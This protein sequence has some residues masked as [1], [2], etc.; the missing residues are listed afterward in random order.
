[1]AADPNDPTW[2]ERRLDEVLAEYL[3]ALDAGRA[4]D[5]AA[6]LARHPELAADLREFFAEQERLDRWT[7]PLRPVAFAAR[8]ER[9]AA[10][11]ASGDGGAG[12]QDDTRLGAVGAF[13]DYDLLRV[14][15]R[16]GMGVVYEARHRR[17]HRL[18]AL[19]MIPAGR[20]ASDTDWQRFR[21]EAEAV[22]HLDH[23]H[24]VP[25]YEVGEHDRRPY[26]SMRRMEGGALADH[27]PRYGGD[28][29]SAARLLIEVAR[30]AHYAHQRGILHRDLKPANVLLDGEGRPYVT[31]FGLAKRLEGAPADEASLT[32]SGALVGSPGYMA[33]EQTTGVRGAVTVASDVYGLGAM[34]YALLT[35][36]PPFRGEDLLSTLDQT[37]HREPE[38]PRKR[39][40]RVDRDLELICLKCLEKDPRR[41]YPGAEALAEELERYLNGRPLAQTRPVGNAERLWRLCRRNPV[42]ASLT[43]VVVV[44]L[45]TVTAVSVV[46][47]VRL[48]EANAQERAS[49]AEAVANRQLA[50]DSVNR[51]FK[52]VSENRGLRA[53]GL[54]RFREELLADAKELY[55]QL[56][57][58]KGDDPAVEAQRGLA[59]WRLAQIT[60]ELGDQREAFRLYQEARAIFERL[61]RDRPQEPDYQV[62][63]ADTL[64]GLGTLSQETGAF[65]AA[66]QIYDEAVP[67][68]E[69]LVADHPDNAGYQD[70]LA[71][72]L[73]Q[74]ARL[75]QLTGQPTRARA[76]LDRALPLFERLARQAPAAPDVQ[77]RLARTYL[78]LGTLHLNANPLEA[79]A[80]RANYDRALPLFARLVRDYPGVP[81]YED[82]LAETLH[83]RGTLERKTNRP[84]EALAS[85]DRAL[86]YRRGL[87]RG[88]EDVPGYRNELATLLH[89]RGLAFQILGRWEE[90][91]A[92]FDE[93]LPL[94]ERLAGDRG[95]KPFYKAELGVL[96]YDSACLYSLF[97]AAT[98][99]GAKPSPGAGRDRAELLAARAVG[100]LRQAREVGFFNNPSM[101]EL[102][103]RGDADLEP[104]RSRSDFRELLNDLDQRAVGKH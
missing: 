63:L 72:T 44:L 42:L 95:A 104:L 28:P 54:E 39:N 14:L 82:K 77:D 37:L 33:P 79:A 56:T 7:E 101:V 55:E 96:Y 25:I 23:P 11:D 24:I 26:F 31:D 58:M 94:R 41:R 32:Q 6:L 70:G 30:A 69:R 53:H 99:E 98:R 21:N 83:V 19:K 90:A 91:K 51:F 50:V 49:K 81:D 9:F 73:H 87:V 62:G 10:A 64:H 74:R 85:Y 35:G 20:W 102:M 75:Y 45:L 34:L 65:A 67:L 86:P 29:R 52:K 48:R 47:A 8:L 61:T 15:G 18:V 43:A 3:K 17:L 57:R 2:R 4:P 97:S 46:A 66:G 71:R 89:A 12:P 5:R 93:A 60:D 80:A 68:R 36:G 84:A 22:A 40:P 38:P 27:L 78:N 92:S 16:G 88:H 76:D 103:R 13:G 100:L 1:M 59:Y